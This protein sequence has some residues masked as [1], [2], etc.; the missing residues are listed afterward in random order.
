MPFEVQANLRSCN[1]RNMC[2][3]ALVV[4]S[5]NTAI[6]FD[7]C[8]KGYMRAWAKQLESDDDNDIE[9]DFLGLDGEKN[10]EHLKK[11]AEDDVEVLSIDDG[12]LYQLNIGN[13]LVP[14]SS[15]QVIIG[16]LLTYVNIAAATLGNSYNT[17]GLCGTFD[18]N[19]RNEFMAMKRTSGRNKGGKRNTKIASLT[20]STTTQI[21][22]D[23]CDHND[24]SQSTRESPCDAFFN[25]W[26]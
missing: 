23:I 6:T 12:R 14:T 7:V 17:L 18:G 19:Q 8:T 20:S 9:E 3:C 13:N 5:R 25:A 24:R 11:L 21:I 1:I 22:E 10:E 16:P 26:R 4:R 15:I 2:I